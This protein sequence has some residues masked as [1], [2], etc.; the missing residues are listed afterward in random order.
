MVGRS[1]AQNLKD[2]QEKEERFPQRR[3]FLAKNVHCGRLKR[4]SL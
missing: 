4:V 1:V 3:W 2:K